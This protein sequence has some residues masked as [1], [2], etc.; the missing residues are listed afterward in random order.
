MAEENKTQQTG[1]GVT[2]TNELQSTLAGSGITDTNEL[3]STDHGQE[4][5][6]DLKARPA[7]WWK[8]P[9]VR[10]SKPGTMQKNAYG[11]S[12]K[13]PTN[14]CERIPLKRY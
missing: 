12:R 9:A 8:S 7:G 11:P 1:S 2:D 10:L 5:A 4:A 14:M 13:M 3:Q 6:K